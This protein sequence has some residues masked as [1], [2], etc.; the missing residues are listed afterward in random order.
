MKTDILIIG[1]GCS[2][3]YCALNLPSDKKITVITKSDLESSD[4]FLA[5]GGICMLKDE[6]DYDRYFED[7][8][9]AGH[10]ENDPVSVKIM[11]NSSRDVIND[12]ISYGTDFA[13]EEDGSF[14]F[15]REGGHCEKRILFHE[16]TTGKEITKTLIAR[17]KE[18]KNIRLLEYTTMLELLTG[19]NTC[20]GAIVKCSDG[21]IRKI[22]SSYT[23]LACGGIGGLFKHST[24]F[25]HLTGDAI[26][27]A[28]RNGIELKDIS[29]IQI[30][31]TTLYCAKEEDRSFLISES[32]RGEGAK[33]YG[34]DKKRF[35]NEL[36][37]RD[38]LTEEIQKQMEKD[39]RDFVWEDLTTIPKD[40]LLGHFPNIV[41]H[42][43][44]MD[45]DVTKE[46]IRVVPA[47]H[48]F[49]GGIKV[50]HES[51]TSMGRLYAVGE[52]ACN[53]VHGK[54]RLAS[55][56]L[57]ESLVFAKRA[58]RQ[59]AETF[60]DI[61]ERVLQSCSYDESEFSDMERFDEYN[62]ELVLGAIKTHKRELENAAG[63]EAAKEK[64]E[65]DVCL[66]K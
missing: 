35:T 22:E 15:T 58:A 42:C 28:I 24:N 27:A 47:Q 53:G 10:Y 66:I 9:K 43:R 7:T 32:V 62:K 57:L 1:S 19:N 8:M 20:A 60:S 38:R 33:L 31:P 21:S 5:Q 6:E 3:L 23:V 45:Y 29:Y 64:K 51:R 54:N 14:C 46:C 18:R 50:D 39:R 55:N 49:M 12:L 41:E 17:A 4:S 65:A 44:R 34:K 40:E 48:Y 13:H 30:H 56:S 59:I 2:G 61:P 52:T 37:P 26:A 16:D 11:I 63:H 36:L 25:R